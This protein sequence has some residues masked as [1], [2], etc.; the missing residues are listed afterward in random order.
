[1][2]AQKVAVVALADPSTDHVR[3]F[4]AFVFVFELKDSGIDTG[5]FLDGSAVKII[6]EIGKNP[7]DA[8]KPLYDRAM[9]EGMIKKACGFC[10]NAFHIKD[11][12]V[13]S[14]VSLTEDNDH[15]SVSGL[16]KD[17]YQIITI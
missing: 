8:I 12:I 10:A 1:M 13:Q 17:G 9:R 4:H 16:V 3:L 15:V 14:K 6:D 5:L 11:K 7:S 2:V